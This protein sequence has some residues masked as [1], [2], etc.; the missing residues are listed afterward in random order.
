MHTVGPARA[1][2]IHLLLHLL[3]SLKQLDAVAHGLNTD[4]LQELIRDATEGA[5]VNVVIL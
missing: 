5:R 1:G 3:G 4:G 2:T